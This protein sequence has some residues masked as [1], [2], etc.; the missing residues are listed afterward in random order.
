MTE[1]DDGLMALMPAL[2]DIAE[3]A[4][5]PLQTRVKGH[6]AVQSG[7]LDEGQV[8]RHVLSAAWTGYVQLYRNSC[9]ISPAIGL[10]CKLSAYIHGD[11]DF[12]CL[13]GGIDGQV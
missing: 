8:L 5:V 10:R 3:Q 2:L 4:G 6:D 13:G 7:L 9:Q 12:Q 11:I 1:S